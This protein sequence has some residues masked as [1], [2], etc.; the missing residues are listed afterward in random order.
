VHPPSLAGFFLLPAY[1]TQAVRE[2]PVYLTLHAAHATSTLALAAT[3]SLLA[4][5]TAPPQLSHQFPRRPTDRP[6]DRRTAP[7]TH[8]SLRLE[9]ITTA[10]T[11]TTCS[12][13]CLTSL[14]WTVFPLFLLVASLPLP[15]PPSLSVKYCRCIIALS[16]A[17]F[18]P[19]HEHA[20][21]VHAAAGLLLPSALVQRQHAYPSPSR[22]GPTI[23]SHQSS[24]CDHSPSPSL[25]SVDTHKP[26][27]NLRIAHSNSTDACVTPTQSQSESHRLLWFDHSKIKLAF[28]S[29]RAAHFERWRI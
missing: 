16:P 7:T 25:N 14:A 1:C 27:T 12:P 13:G 11:T 6:C 2:L 5:D 8:A 10:S 15:P 20:S 3:F 22:S 4:L 23:R 21:F 26:P 24:F 28:S 29:A 18:S 9:S 19:A 17:D